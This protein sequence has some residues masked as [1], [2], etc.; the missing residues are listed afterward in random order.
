MMLGLTVHQPYAQ[1]LAIGAKQYETRSYPTKYRGKV[2]IHAGLNTES[3]KKFQHEYNA[4][5]KIN[6]PIWHY[7]FASNVAHAVETYKRKGEEVLHYANEYVYQ[8]SDFP[9]GSIIAYADLVNCYSCEDVSSAMILTEREALFGGWSLGR[10][11]WKMD[12]V[13]MLDEPLP[14]KGFQRLFRL[15][16]DIVSKVLDRGVKL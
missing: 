8:D 5:V 7:M 2:A 14:Y 12:N 10:Y 15:P 1:L 13:V 3:L 4:W 16:D 11:A 6:R 9:L